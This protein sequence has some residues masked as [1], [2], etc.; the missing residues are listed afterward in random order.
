MGLLI[1][2]TYSQMLIIFIQKVTTT[3]CEYSLQTLAKQKL[4]IY[5]INTINMGYTVNTYTSEALE[6]L[7]NKNNSDQWYCRKISTVILQ[8][9]SMYRNSILFWKTCIKIPEVPNF[10]KHMGISVTY[11]NMRPPP[12]T[13]I[14][15]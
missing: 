12:Y 3:I 5:V 7:S 4:Q 11:K 15:N 1:Q 8:T 6:N 13:E 10:G 2:V 14:N 9:Y